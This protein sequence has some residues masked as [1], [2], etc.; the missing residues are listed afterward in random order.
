MGQLQELPY[1]VSV[2]NQ[3]RCIGKANNRPCRAL[4]GLTNAERSS[5]YI[6]RRDLQVFVHDLGGV[7]ISVICRHCGETNWLFSESVS[8]DQQRST[9]ASQ[10]QQD[11]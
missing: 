2:D 9:K 4:L 5:V 1:P 6:L 8:E 10:S 7:G 11:Y 3:W